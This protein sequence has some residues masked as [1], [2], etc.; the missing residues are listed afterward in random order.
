MENLLV[1]AGYG[2]LILFGFLE[3]CCVPISS[4]VTFGFAG[5]LAY[6]GH[7][8][9]ALVI[10]L[11]TLAELA[12]S[13]VAY[14]VGRV[15]ERPVIERLGRY[16]LITRADLDRAERFL[17]GR[18]VWAI[19][20]GRAL[21]VVRAFTSI[22][23]GLAGVPALRFGVL[24]LIGTLIY[25]TVV[26]SIGYSLGSAWHRVAHVLALAGYVIAVLIVAGIAAF[27]IYRLREVRREAKQQ[28]ASPPASH[29]A[30]GAD[31]PTAGQAGQD[32]GSP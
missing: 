3:A 29:R 17:V 25:V 30:P 21:P 12:G 9:L 14:A 31:R 26:A 6:Q 27:L 18:G 20:L 8:N 10:L 16:V 1:H 7:L 28:G 2:A 15:A 23:A 22:A 5:V 4:E 13:Y 24:S 11:G 32:G 19:P